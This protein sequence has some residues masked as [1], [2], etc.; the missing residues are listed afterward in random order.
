MSTAAELLDRHEK[1][2]HEL[3]AANLALLALAR[4]QTA[5]AEAKAADDD[6]WTRM[7]A[8]KRRCHVSGWSRS[9]IIRRIKESNP[10]SA[11]DR[12]VRGKTVKGTSYYSAADV[13]RYVNAL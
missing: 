8:G 5:D 12:I 13:R 11:P 10:A 4:S 6:E 1:A 7:P 9:T 2:L 3:H